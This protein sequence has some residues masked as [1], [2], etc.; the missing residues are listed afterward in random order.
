MMFREMKN[1]S[2]LL[3]VMIFSLCT[4]WWSWHCDFG[5][6]GDW[7]WSWFCLLWPC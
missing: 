6:D 5:F 4:V 2:S 7:P 1:R 3:Y